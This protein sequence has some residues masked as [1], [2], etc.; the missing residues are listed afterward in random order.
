[1]NKFTLDL[2]KLANEV[3]SFLYRFLDEKETKSVFH[4]PLLWLDYEIKP[5]WIYNFDILIDRR[6]SLTGCINNLFMTIF[7]YRHFNRYTNFCF[8]NELDLLIL[9]KINLLFS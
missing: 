9:H 1:M 5:L 2:H 4:A 8:Y 7:L 3:L 6:H